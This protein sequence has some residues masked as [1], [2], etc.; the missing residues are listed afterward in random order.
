MMRIIIRVLVV[1]CMILVLGQT[2]ASAE[3]YLGI[4]LSSFLKESPCALLGRVVSVE[5]RDEDDP[6]ASDAQRKNW[7]LNRVVFQAEEKIGACGEI[8]SPSSS[9]TTE[10]WLSVAVHAS[11]PVEGEKAILFPGRSDGILT[12]RF[13]G[14]SYWPLKDYDSKLYVFVSWRN[15]F[16]LDGVRLGSGETG[17]IS[18]SAVLKYLRKA[19]S[20]GGAR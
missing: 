4:T 19:L 20:A 17:H 14:V 11:N 8:F 5:P 18:A 7:L 2:A 16:L 1:C 12:E 13:L 9:D 3:L 6:R 15:D 10:L